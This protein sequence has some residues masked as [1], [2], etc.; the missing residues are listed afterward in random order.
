VDTLMSRTGRSPLRWT[1]GSA[2][3]ANTPCRNGRCGP[4]RPSAKSRPSPQQRAEWAAKAGRLGAYSGDVRLG[5]SRRGDRFR[6]R[7]HLPRGPRRRARRIRGH[8][9]GGGH[10]CTPPHRRPVLRAAPR[11][12][13]RGL[14]AP[15]SCR[16]MSLWPTPDPLPA[17]S[18]PHRSPRRGWQR[19]IC[20]SRPA[21]VGLVLAWPAEAG[22]VHGGRAPSRAGP[23]RRPG[24]SWLGA[25]GR[26]CSRL[27]VLSLSRR[28]GLRL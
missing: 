19:S 21:P 11:V 5:P 1:T 8:G 27:A 12:R 23:L 26:R 13:G 24:E 9:P 16:C 10:R 4:L 22:A 2:A 14:Q 7:Y 3:S 25:S 17:R 28:A 6:A 20:A 15:S 18:W